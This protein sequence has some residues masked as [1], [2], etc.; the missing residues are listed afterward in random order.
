MLN[1]FKCNYDFY[2]SFREPLCLSM[3]DHVNIIKIK[4]IVRKTK[5][6]Y[7]LV[8]P[9]IGCDLEY[10]SHGTRNTSFTLE[11]V[12]YVAYRL[13]GALM[14]MHS[15]GIVHRD[16]QATS[17]VIATSH[18]P[19]MSHRRIEE[20]KLVSFANARLITTEGCTNITATTPTLFG[21][22]GKFVNK[23]GQPE[24]D[25]LPNPAQNM[26]QWAP[27]LGLWEEYNYLLSEDFDWR[28]CDVWALGCVLATVLRCGEPLFAAR[29]ASNH[30]SEILL[31]HELRPK[32]TSFLQKEVFPIKSRWPN[33]QKSLKELLI[34]VPNLPQRNC[35]P[36][37]NT[38]AYRQQ[39]YL[40]THSKYIP[41]HAKPQ[42]LCS[43]GTRCLDLIIQMLTFEPSQR[44]SCEEL[45][46]HAFFDSVQR[47]PSIERL[48]SQKLR[49]HEKRALISFVGDCGGS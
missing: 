25:K 12:Q 2:T 36:I 5:D 24:L 23:F 9:Y 22:G 45:L 20:V 48:S 49:V 1:E 15:A 7:Y 41:G 3:L 44:P 29:K 46:N 27:E 16:I 30:L 34:S 42:Q 8:M 28:K 43:L 18:H 17:V 13:L 14:Y 6:S 10:F 32:D 38:E 37:F 26:W 35:P 33:G 21:V 39:Q 47:D 31:V 40:Q 4:G 11:Q 19:E